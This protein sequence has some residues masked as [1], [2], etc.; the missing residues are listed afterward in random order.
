MAYTRSTWV[1]DS[2]PDLDATHLNNI[3]TGIANLSTSLNVTPTARQPF[4]STQTL[5]PGLSGTSDKVGHLLQTVVSGSTH[6]S[7]SGSNPTFCWGLNVFTATGTGASDAAGVRV[8]NLIEADVRAS[9]G[10]ITNVKGL[11]A[12]ASFFGA[13]AGATVTDMMSLFVA[14]P[15]RKDGATAGTATNVYGLKVQQVNAVDTGATTAFS[16]YVDG[17]TSFFGGNISA[18]GITLDVSASSTGTVK[19]RSG[20]FGPTGQAADGRMIV[21]GDGAATNNIFTVKNFA[22][23]S[24]APIRLVESDGTTVL[25]SFTAAGLPRWN[26]AAN[27]QTTVGAAGGGSALP[28]TPVKYLKVVDS[29]GTTLVIPAYNA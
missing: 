25:F 8:L 24:N 3:E 6:G 16:L 10:T 21:A 14:A 4:V 1:N 19:S 29:A 15:V 18:P 9:S 5:T 13:T 20:I 23:Q 2:T 28:A 12:E 26:P 17:G 27:Q 11:Q 22:S 7:D